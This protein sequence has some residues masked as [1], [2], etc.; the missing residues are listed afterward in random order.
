MDKALAV[1][2]DEFCKLRTGRASTALI[3][4]LRVDYYGTPTP[5]N[6]MATITAPEARLLVVQPWDPSALGEIEKTLMKADLGVSP[7]NDGKLIRIP[8]PPMTEERRKDLVKLIHKHGEECRIAIRNVRRNGME[9]LKTAEKDKKM[10]QDEHKKGQTKVQ[11][12]TDSHI[13]KVDQLVETKSR[14]ILEV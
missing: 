14:E 3:D 4:T 11:E 5:L 12:L 2:K 7:Q 10:T 6:Q 13:K 1:L 8:L 9:E